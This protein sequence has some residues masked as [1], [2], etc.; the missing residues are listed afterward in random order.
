[1]KKLAIILFS[2]L[3]LVGCSNT[4]KTTKLEDEIASLKN[5]IAQ[6]KT[7]KEQ[8]EKEKSELEQKLEEYEK[9][10]NENNPGDEYSLTL[11]TTLNMAWDYIEA[12]NRND[13]QTLEAIL[14]SKASIDRANNQIL[15]VLEGDEKYS[16]SLDEYRYPLEDFQYRG[17]GFGKDNNTFTI[18]FSFVG[19]EGDDDIYNIETEMRFINEN[20]EWKLELM[21]S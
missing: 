9:Y 3:L 16:V 1:M 8:L 7:E 18:Y 19:G 4:E 10:T 11:N 12:L 15:F 21:I 13:F 20:G 17:A 14:S 5:E 6:V 2:G